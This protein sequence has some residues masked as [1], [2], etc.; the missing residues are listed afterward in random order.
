MPRA[1]KPKVT[2]PYADTKVHYLKSQGEIGALLS[3]NGVQD[4][5]FTNLSSIGQLILEFTRPQMLPDGREIRPA[6]RI[7]VPDINDDNRNQKHRLLYWFLKSKFEALEAGLVEF[8]E[9][10]FPYMLVPHGDR[11][12]T[13][14]EVL[15]A[16]YTQA[17]ASGQ[18]PD[19]Q[20]LPG[21]RG[22]EV[23]P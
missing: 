6:V 5:R 7:L 11:V 22:G 16:R 23:R 10:F 12:A 8:I 18:V 1:S 15:G 13:I 17:L 4:T 20:L 3:K 2:G 21:P 19:L 9:E 14:Y